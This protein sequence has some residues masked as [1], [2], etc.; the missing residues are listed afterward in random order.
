VTIESPLAVA[1][2]D[3]RR[4]RLPARLE[5]NGLAAAAVGFFALIVAVTLRQQLV[6]D[7]WLALLSGREIAEHGLPHRDTL[8]AWTA[9]REWIDQ[10]W[11]AHLSYYGL[12]VVGGIRLVL[13]LHVACVVAAAAILVRAARRRGASSPAVFLTGFVCLLMAPWALQMRAQSIAELLFAATLVLLLDE[14][15]LTWRRLAA[16]LALLVLW[17][18]VHGTVVLGVALAVLRGAIVL[19]RGQRLRGALLVLAAP[20]CVVASPYGFEL[21]GYYHRMLA[22]PLMARYVGEWQRPWPG[23]A[24]VAFYVVVA[25]GTWRLA[26]HRR[27]STVFDRAAFALLGL[28]ALQALRGIVWFGLAAVPILAPQL[29]GAI[30]R[31]RLLGSPLVARAGLGVA[32]AG[33]IVACAVFAQPSGWFVRDWPAQ[34]AA[35][36]AAVAAREPGAKV[37]ADDEYADWL[38]WSQPSLRGRIAYDIRFELFTERQ[39]RAVGRYRATNAPPRPGDP[40]YGA[41][42]FVSSPRTASCFSGRCR[43][44]YRDRDVL[45]ARS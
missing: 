21:V 25:A 14:R 35:D 28:V 22:N 41:D 27:S 17:A 26:R 13:A 43:T 31:A 23:P 32:A 11:L 2:P 45:V 3:S 37:F 7:S 44:V 9:G 5:A 24:T 33:A 39:F 19:A 38:L 34:A 29:D 18:N 4:L 30:A 10:Q 6:Q 40:L 16:I 42:V 12:D 36:V 20:C 1:L 8:F 15:A